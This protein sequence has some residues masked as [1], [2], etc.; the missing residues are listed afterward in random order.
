MI[1]ENERI[2]KENKWFFTF[3]F[4]QNLGLFAS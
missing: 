1:N 3:Q 4:Y 2:G